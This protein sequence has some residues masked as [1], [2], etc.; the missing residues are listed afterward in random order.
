MSNSS[1]NVQLPTKKDVQ[2]PTVEVWLFIVE[3]ISS[4]KRDKSIQKGGKQRTLKNL[5]FSTIRNNIFKEEP[6]SFT[7]NGMRRVQTFF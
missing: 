2:L 6:E 1:T 7:D 4:L 3:E 5:I